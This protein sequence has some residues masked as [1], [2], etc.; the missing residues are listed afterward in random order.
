MRSDALTLLRVTLLAAVV[1]LG[2]L[3]PMAGAQTA[4]SI[5]TTLSPQAAEPPVVLGDDGRAEVLVSE[6][7]LLLVSL[8]GCGLLIAGLEALEVWRERR[9]EP[10]TPR[11][12]IPGVTPRGAVSTSEERWPVHR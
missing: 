12:S 2:P 7:I 4:S 11:A 8:L 1:L 3:M 5:E 6:T 9:V 10:N